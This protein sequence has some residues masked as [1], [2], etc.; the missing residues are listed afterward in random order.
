[1]KLPDGGERITFRQP[2]G[3]AVAAEGEPPVLRGEDHQRIRA[4]ERI[5]RP[6]RTALDGFEQERVRA[7][8][9]TEIGRERRVE[10]GWELGKHGHKIAVCR[11]SPKLL[12]ARRKGRDAYAGGTDADPVGGALGEGV[13]LCLELGFGYRADHLIGDLALLHEKDGRDRADPVS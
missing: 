12:T 13:Q 10:I 7:G 6:D 11:E 9:Q 2:L 1:E 5:T 4:E 8:P 3:P